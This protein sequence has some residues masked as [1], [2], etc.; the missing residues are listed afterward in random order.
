MFDSD[1]SWLGILA[2]AGLAFIL[3]RGVW[4]KDGKRE[5]SRKGYGVG[6]NRGRSEGYT[7]GKQVGSRRG[8]AAAKRKYKDNKR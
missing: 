6:R 1:A 4:F 8:F 2:I 5:G 3:A 7:Y